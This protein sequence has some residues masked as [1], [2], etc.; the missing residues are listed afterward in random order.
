MGSFHQKNSLLHEVV[1]KINNWDIHMSL[2][3][4]NFAKGISKD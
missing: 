4:L 1:N 3:H 2:H